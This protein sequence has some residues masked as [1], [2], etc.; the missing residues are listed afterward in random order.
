[1]LPVTA[2]KT[3]VVCPPL[4]KLSHMHLVHMQPL[5]REHQGTEQHSHLK[6]LKLLG[7]HVQTVASRLPVAVA[8]DPHLLIIMLP[9]GAQLTQHHT[10]TST[11]WAVDLMAHLNS[12]P[13]KISLGTFVKEAPDCRA[14][15]IKHLQS[16][17]KLTSNAAETWTPAT[18]RAAAE[19][20][21]EQR[22]TVRPFVPNRPAEPPQGPVPMETR[23][24]TRFK[25]EACYHA[26]HN[27]SNKFKTVVKAEVEI[28]GKVFECILDT[29]AS[30]TVLS[31]IVDRR[32]GHWII[33]YPAA[34]ISL[35]Q[36]ARLRSL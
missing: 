19:P 16:F 12:T 30:D 4:Q 22:P 35:Q 10:L 21:S 6:A 11:T 34:S 33:W 3:M 31:H 32:L 2:T 13:M 20:A 36:Q 5:C 1:M 26:D 15:L 18:K 14:D 17:N 8:L 28:L 23:F 25:T 27:K 7:M 9:G 24:K 29:G